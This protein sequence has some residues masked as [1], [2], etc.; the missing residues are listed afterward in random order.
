MECD[1]FEICISTYLYNTVTVVS[2]YLM[3]EEYKLDD[4]TL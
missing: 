2:N 4:K 1:V 3:L